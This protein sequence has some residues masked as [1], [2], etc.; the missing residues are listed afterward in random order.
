VRV[1]PTRYLIPFE[2]SCV[3]N[4]V[5]LA[6]IAHG[7]WRTASILVGA[8]SAVLF[9]TLGL[10]R[11]SLDRQIAHYEREIAFARA[12]LDGEATL[13]GG[14]TRIVDAGSELAPPPPEPNGR[15]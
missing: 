1:P 4:F 5:A 13:S 7:A 12:V 15:R 6:L 8:V 9:L 2:V 11:Y 3:L 14:R 10:L